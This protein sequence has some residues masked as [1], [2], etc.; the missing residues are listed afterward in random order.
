MK[1]VTYWT[2]LPAL[3]G[4]L[5]TGCANGGSGAEPAPGAKPDDTPK[6]PAEPVE[7]IFYSNSGEAEESFNGK[8]GDTLRAKFPEYTI[9]YTRAEKGAMIPEIIAAGDRVDIIYNVFDYVLEPLLNY[10]I[11]YDM[12]ELAKKHGVDLA[13]FEP[14]VI[15]GIRR[16]GS[17]KLYM[18]PT[19]LQV[20]MVFYNKEIFDKFGVPYPKDGMTWDEM[21]AMSQKLTRKDGGVQYFGFVGSQPFSLK[22]NPFSEPY[23]DEKTGKSTF[24]R[25]TWKK[26]I[27]TVFLD[28]DSENALKSQVQ[29]KNA[30][31]NRIGF[32][33]TK[34]VAM[35]HFH[36]EFPIA[37]PK[38]LEK[39]DW[40]MVAFPTFKELNGVGGQAAA[41]SMSITSIAKNKDAAMEVI[42]YLT[43][44]EVQTANSKKGVMSVLK[45]ESVKAAFGQESQF[46]GK[47]WKGVYFNKLA[48]IPYRSVYEL[49]V[50]R[51]YSAAI[52]EVIKG[53]KDINTIMR[54]T[55]ALTDKKVAELQSAMKK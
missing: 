24:E 46:K 27:Q 16:A 25:E 32:T 1:K 8:F 50:E 37:V 44:L 34:D 55:A 39:I 4:S 13:A 47:N 45:E 12:T 29:A 33:N 5:L 36:S 53:Q 7:L 2:L 35:L 3:F 6:K 23:L 43:S 22:L 10:G 20:P 21:K 19:S 49:E 42:K 51:I 41:V 26:M 11:Q 52:A 9:K 28:T 54:E 38:E 40:D 30:L 15:D 14:S 18:L 17:G 48:P 31:P